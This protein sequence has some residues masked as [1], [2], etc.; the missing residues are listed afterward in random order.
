[1]HFQKTKIVN[2]S[3]FT[4]PLRS[5]KTTDRMAQAASAK[6]SFFSFETRLFAALRDWHHKKSMNAHLRVPREILQFQNSNS[7]IVYRH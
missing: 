1:M 4:D 6:I 3:A 7:N 2:F 5:Y